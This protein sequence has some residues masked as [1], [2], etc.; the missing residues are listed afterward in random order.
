M[1]EINLKEL[2]DYFK[3]RIMLFLIIL[4]AI[5]VLGSIYSVFIKTPLYQSQVT[6]LLVSDGSQTSNYTSSDAQLNK[7]LVG[8]YTEIVKPKRVV[9]Q[10][11][12]NLSLN[13]TVGE[14]INSISVSA[15][16]DTEVIKITVTNEDRAIAAA[17]ANEV[18][19]VFSNE[20]KELYQ[21]QNISVVDSA[22]E[23]DKAYNVNLIKDLFI[24][25]IVG[26]VVG[27]AVVF[28]IYYFDTTIKSATEIEEKFGLPIFG[29]V[30]LVKSREKKGE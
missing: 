2:L 16:N 8:T 29:V 30:P 18:V 15:V 9:E 25:I 28:V 22:E 21:I 24:Y 11:I 12:K 26:I 20:V 5:V 7:S 13:T 19:K 10:V 23:A 17:V 27:A 4:L 1:E 6:V 14:L 3:E